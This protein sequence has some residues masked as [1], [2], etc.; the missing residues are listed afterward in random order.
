[1]ISK[2]INF[3]AH[4]IATGEYASAYI[5]TEG[6]SVEGTA[7]IKVGT[8]YSKGSNAAISGVP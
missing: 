2:V 1:M 5:T 6:E 3:E 8:L 7:A 4:S